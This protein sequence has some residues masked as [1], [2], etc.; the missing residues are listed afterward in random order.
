MYCPRRRHERE[1]I[2][3]MEDLTLEK[4]KGSKKIASEANT[5][6]PESTSL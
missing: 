1:Q 4:K 2:I 5:T 6:H 3:S